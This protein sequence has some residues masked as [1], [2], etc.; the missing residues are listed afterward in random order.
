[1]LLFFGFTLDGASFLFQLFGTIIPKRGPTSLQ[2]VGCSYSILV[3][4]EEW[5]INNHLV[6]TKIAMVKIP[7]IHL[8]HLFLNGPFYLWFVDWQVL[9]PVVVPENCG[10]VQSVVRPGANVM[11]NYL[12]SPI[13]AQSL[14]LTIAT[15]R[16]FLLAGYYTTRPAVA[17]SG[18]PNGPK[19]SPKVGPTVIIPKKWCECPV[20][21]RT[22]Q[23][24]NVSE[25]SQQL[26]ISR[27]G[28]FLRC[29]GGAPQKLGTCPTDVA[30]VKG[31]RLQAGVHL[32]DSASIQIWIVKRWGCSATKTQAKKQVTGTC[33]LWW[34]NIAIEN[35]HR[36]SGFSH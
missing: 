30:S 8:T 12:T 24:A 9:V 34:T 1:M 26:G 3:W 5:N 18:F 28:L 14:W 23:L 4:G 29:H 13:S 25:T 20:N 17:I 2:P 19:V 10:N 11:M 35:G 7:W 22:F 6:M 16:F 21:G 27:L 31:T 33:T 15:S 32:G 36:N